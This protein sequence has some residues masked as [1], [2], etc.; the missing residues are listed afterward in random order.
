MAVRNHF[1]NIVAVALQRNFPIL[2]IPANAKQFCSAAA[3]AAIDQ[4]ETA[5]HRT[6]DCSR[7]GDA[8][9]YIVGRFLPQM[10]N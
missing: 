2:D 4:S 7:T 5:V 8:V 10:M 6:A 9:E 3:V 1:P